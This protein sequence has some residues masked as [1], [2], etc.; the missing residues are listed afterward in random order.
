MVRD[1]STSRVIKEAA[2]AYGAVVIGDWYI[3]GFYYSA[4]LI[5]VTKGCC[6]VKRKKRHSTRKRL[7]VTLIESINYESIVRKR[8]KKYKPVIA[9]SCHRTN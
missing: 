3:R 8:L 1:S 7:Y 9:E 2:M 4:A 5:L 6:Y